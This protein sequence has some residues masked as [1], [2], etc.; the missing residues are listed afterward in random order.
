MISSVTGWRWCQNC[1]IHKLWCTLDLTLHRDGSFIHTHTHTNTDRG[2][3]CDPFTHY[4]TPAGVY[5]PSIQTRPSDCRCPPSS[6]RVKHTHTPP[7]T[8][9]A[10]RF[11]CTTCCFTG[12]Y[13]VCFSCT[14]PTR[15]KTQ[16]CTRDVLAHWLVPFIAAKLLAVLT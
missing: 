14:C 12:C 7:V 3:M 6:M 4:P 1:V 10:G 13:E 5:E 2:V 8:N 11:L 16:K 9:G 15:I